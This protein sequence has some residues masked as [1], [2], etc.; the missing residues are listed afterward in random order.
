MIPD[1]LDQLNET[2]RHRHRLDDIRDWYQQLPNILGNTPSPRLDLTGTRSTTSRIPGGDTLTMLAPWAPDADHGDDLPHPDQIIR[3]WSH[4]IHDAH[5]T[6]P[7]PHATWAQHWRYLWDQTPTILASA[8]TDA[9]TTD[10]NALWH[11]LSHLTGNTERE[12]ENHRGPADC[13]ALAPEIPDTTL[14]T[15]PEA[16]TFAPGIRNRID[17]D[18]HHERTRA[19]KQQRTPQ[20]RCTPDTKGRYLVGD[21]RE[22][23]GFNTQARSLHPHAKNM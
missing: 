20:Y 13:L 8:F 11:R 6:V 9:W 23:Y 21:L 1:D 5:G 17:V 15:L 2:N 19:K 14:L 12:E 3:E 22:H 10:I 16:E 7:T 18:R 4:T